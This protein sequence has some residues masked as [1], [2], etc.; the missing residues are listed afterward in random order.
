[1]SGALSERAPP[2]GSP[3]LH[4]SAFP[5]SRHSFARLSALESCRLRGT[6]GP[7]SPPRSAQIPTRAPALRA[8]A[9]AGSRTRA[10]GAVASERVLRP[11]EPPPLQGPAV[12]PRPVPA[13]PIPPP[14]PPPPRLGL[15]CK[16]QPR[17]KGEGL[18]SRL[19]S[20]RLTTVSERVRQV[21]PEAGRREAPNV[22]DLRGPREMNGTRG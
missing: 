19:T 1:M 16:V 4:V 22:R 2:D 13:R 6:P 7:A 14:P 5:S 20:E 18:G 17:R 10:P 8:Q 15:G 21:G 9:F 12:S 11:A 3:C